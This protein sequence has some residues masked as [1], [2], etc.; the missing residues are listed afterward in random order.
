MLHNPG[1]RVVCQ[2]THFTGLVHYNISAYLFV[3]FLFLFLFCW[4]G[5][6]G[7]AILKIDC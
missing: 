1:L 7:L 6:G 3:C 2:V 5:G 4:G